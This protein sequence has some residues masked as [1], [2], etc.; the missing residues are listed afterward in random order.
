MA[1]VLRTFLE[2]LSRQRFDWSERNCF[3]VCADWVKLV[4]GR[5]PAARWR[6]VKSQAEARRVVRRAGGEIV[7]VERAMTAFGA[8]TTAEPRCGDVA[9]VTAP[10]SRRGDRVI[11]RPTG[12]ICVDGTKYAILTVDL[13]LVVWPLPVVRAWRVEWAPR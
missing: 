6:H 13:G 2:E 11:Y 5:D 12:A 9:L 8:Q 10:R 3:T 7:L 1:E 4:T